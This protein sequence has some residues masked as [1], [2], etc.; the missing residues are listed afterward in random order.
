MATFNGELFIKQQILSILV[1]LSCDDEIIVS[2]DGSTDNTLDII[3]D[4]NDRRIKVYKNSGVNGYVGNFENSLNL[5]SGDVIFLSDQDDIWFPNKVNL[6]LEQLKT[7][8]FVITDA[9]IVNAKLDVVEDSYFN[10]R[11]TSFG[12]FSSLIRCRYLGC[13]YAFRNT[14]LRKAL[15]FPPNHKYLPH[16]LWLALIG[17]FFYSVSYLKVP[18]IYYRRHSNNTSDGG[19]FSSNSI[20]TKIK[21]RLYSLVCIVKVLFK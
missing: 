13:C 18:L 9:I 10:A 11:K 5:A 7:N 19:N 21:I 3:N 20:F 8:E 15:P 1:Q 14:V 12:F 17:E 2:D 4:I 6:V 16:D